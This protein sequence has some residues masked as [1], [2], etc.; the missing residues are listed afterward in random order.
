M[1]F[2]L[3]ILC[4]ALQEPKGGRPVLPADALLTTPVQ[5]LQSTNATANLI[6][7][8]G[9]GFSTALQVIVRKD[10][11]E[12]NAT[13]L[14]IPIS[15]PMKAGDT[16]LATFW[17]R[18]ERDTAH[19]RLLFEMTTSPWTKSV[20]FDARAG[21]AWRRF[22]VPF[23]AA[24]SYSAG[25]AMVSFRFAFG[26]QSVELGG[27]DVTDFG[28][29]QSLDSLANS[30]L[31]RS[32]LGTVS[33]NFDTKHPHQKMVGLGG[34]FC[35][36]R[37]GSTE[38][39]DVVGNYVLS[40]LPVD[41]ARVGLPLNYW[42]PKQGEDHDDAQA[43]AS[44]QT[45]VLLAKRKIPIVM[46]I[47]NGPQWLVGVRPD[48]SGAV[49]PP[50]Q[51]GPCIDAIAR[52]LVHARDKYGVQVDEI[53][54]N[55]PEEGV[56]LKFTPQTMVDFIRLAGPVFKN[57][58]LKTKF[59]V[60]DNGGGSEAVAFDTPILEEPSVREY[61]GP[62][63]FH[64]WDAMNVNDAEYESIRALGAKFGKPIWCLECG[65]DAGLWRKSGNPFST[66][67]NALNDALAY[68][69][70]ICLSGASVMDY[71]TYQDNY[72]IVDKT[73]P[74]P[75][76]SLG[77]IRQLEAVFAP[78]QKVVIAQSG[79]PDLRAL[80]T[81]DSKGT[82]SVLLINSVGSGKA[83]VNG[84]RPNTLVQVLTRDQWAGK[85]S[86]AKTTSSGTLTVA[87][88]TRSVST[89]VPAAAKQ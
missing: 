86:V 65:Y 12:T 9:N 1:P 88:P 28:T 36:A 10:S 8:S 72:P 79:S 56:N 38:A 64:C 19:I 16:L 25:Q 43:A 32:T 14:T 80:G 29:S 24:D 48:Q 31:A 20:I 67:D 84:F 85:S 78:R 66:W 40:H 5:G 50:S 82:L 47:W 44:F 46:S 4:L 59:L 51:Y 60:G 15:A 73:G 62:I 87:L 81:I 71:W 34:D 11:A 27:I 26:P 18:A 23:A 7:A 63:S 61:L 77:V 41:H 53:S 83:V 68:E 69:K 55:E 54:F 89:I 2:A 21:K 76:P 3:A 74:T 39:M 6:D 75:Y 13:Q 49:L 30:L 57:L 42:E 52:Y 58:G 35:Q 37:Y 45:L 33:V 22:Q 17:L 70:T